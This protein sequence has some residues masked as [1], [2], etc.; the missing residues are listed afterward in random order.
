M[1]VCIYLEHFYHLVARMWHT[2]D[3]MEGYHLYEPRN[4][5]CL[6]KHS[7]AEQYKNAHNIQHIQIAALGALD[8]YRPIPHNHIP[9]PRFRSRPKI[10]PCAALA[11]P[12]WLV[13]AG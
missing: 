9:S 6:S 2:D 10:T 12:L 11:R 3:S 4:A 7:L 5:T 1:V 8:P 13:T